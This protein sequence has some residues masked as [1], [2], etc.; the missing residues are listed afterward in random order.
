MVNECVHGQRV[1][2][3]S[4]SVCMVNECVHGQRVYAWSTSVCMV[5]ECMHGQQSTKKANLFTVHITIDHSTLTKRLDTS[6]I[7]LKR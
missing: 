5:N 4:T 1:Y 2:A 3:W 7:P 6:A